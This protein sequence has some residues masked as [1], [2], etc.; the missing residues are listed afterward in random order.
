MFTKHME[1]CL[2]FP[3]IAIKKMQINTTMSSPFPPTKRAIIKTKDIRKVGEGKKKLELS[4]TAGRNVNWPNS[5]ESSLRVY[6][7][8]KNGVFIDSVISHLGICAGE[9]KTYVNAKSCTQMFA[10]A[11]S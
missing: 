1:I 5:S 3:S 11:F 10:A 9:I 2:I 4:Y 8:F 6:K 7:K